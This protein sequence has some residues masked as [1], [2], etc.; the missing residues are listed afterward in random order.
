M[1][2]ACPKEIKTLENRVG[3]TPAGTKILV[4]NGHKV[5]VERE[6]GLGSG[7]SNAEYIEAGAE[8]IDTAKEI[9]DKGEIIIK[10]K[11]PLE[12]EYP[13]IQ[14]N[15]I[16][17]T[18]FHF[19]SS[20]SLIEAMVLSKSVC[21]AYET[22]KDKNGGLPLLVPMS[23][24]AGRL[25][26]LEGIR[27]LTKP[28]GGLGILPGGI[29][30]LEPAKITIIGG[31]MVGTEAAKIAAGL[32]ADVTILDISPSRLLY[33]SETLP[34]NVKTLFSNET[35][36]RK[37]LLDTD[38]LVGAVLIP[39]AEAPK[40][41][42]EEMV[43]TMKKGSVIVDVAID[44]GGC[45]ATSLKTS[46]DKPIFEKHGVIHYC[47]ANM[48]GAVARTA[49]LALTQVTFPYLLKLANQGYKQLAENDKGF[50]EGIN[51][52]KGKI[53]LSEIK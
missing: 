49:T 44:Q 35:N 20:K 26:I 33:L 2:I 9:Y 29:P 25:S 53:V 27:F 45:V 42:S 7:F 10:V 43:K 30:G 22:I 3:L 52:E 51:I 21:I 17:F 5:F 23:Q 32:G 46:F 34:K 37:L 13:F 8:I 4:Q 31:G 48:P 14:E 12:Q 39:G 41:V 11:E 16:I 19:A 47:V 1:K 28:F 50:A 18:Y 6:A 24:I 40:L 36:L 15:Q 38:L